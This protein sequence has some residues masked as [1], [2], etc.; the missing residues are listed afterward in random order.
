MD[1]HW[2]CRLSRGG[3]KTTVIA[4]LPEFYERAT[5]PAKL[6][7]LIR[8][9]HN[10]DPD[11]IVWV[12]EQKRKKGSRYVDDTTYLKVGNRWEVAMAELPEQVL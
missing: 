5:K 8:E 3:L 1:G 2:E 10:C 9:S 4:T 6:A 12:I 7:E 11:E